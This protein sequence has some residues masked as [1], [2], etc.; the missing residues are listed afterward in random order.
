MLG[1]GSVLPCRTLCLASGLEASLQG[2]REEG[3]GHRHFLSMGAEDKRK[4]WNS[5]AGLNFCSPGPRHTEKDG[6]SLWLP[7][8]HR[9][10]L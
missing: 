2:Q 1:P 4:G 9:C 10:S 8:Y 6:L 7:W 5:Q 3:Q